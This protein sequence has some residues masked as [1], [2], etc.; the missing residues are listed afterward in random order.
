MLKLTIVRFFLLFSVYS[1]TVV[2]VP[3]VVTDISPTHS[4]VS[5]VME[6]VGQ[7]HLVV[8]LGASPHHYIIRP[9]NAQVLETADLVF[10]I[11]RELTS[12]IIISLV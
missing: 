1:T 3:T 10:W 9:S 7:P 4:L 12:L 11:S 2:A 8:P 5:Q 6:G